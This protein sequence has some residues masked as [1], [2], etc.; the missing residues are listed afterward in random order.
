MPFEKV[1]IAPLIELIFTLDQ[2]KIVERQNPVG[3]GMRRENTAEHS[4]SLALAVL[5]FRAH[6]AED[7]DIE[8]AVALA[9]S[10]D[11]PEAFVGDTFVY[12]ADAGQRLEREA[13][14][15]REFVGTGR[16]RV[17]LDLAGLWRE[18]EAGDSAE[19]RYVAALDVL[20]PVLM[21]GRNPEAS[22]W[23]RH[24]VSSDRVRAR[25]RAVEHVV[26]D[27]AAAAHRFID[28]GVRSGALRGS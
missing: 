18:F 21:N 28:I 23:M 16:D 19:S 11:L 5:V 3:N 25:V 9:V 1:P 4:W 27:L 26:P 7:L 6:A 22:S 24:G 17:R 10:H 14:A 12:G 20:L 2:L 15:M 13:T 8:H